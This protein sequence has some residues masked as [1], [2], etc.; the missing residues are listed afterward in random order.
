MET[1]TLNRN[2]KSSR[3]AGRTP[4]IPGPNSIAEVA[5][6]RLGNVD[7]WVMIRGINKDNP[8]LVMLHGGP[9]MS[10]TVFW[11]YYNSEALEKIFTVV[12]WDQRGSG[13][14]FDP[15]LD[16]N[17]MTVEQF[18]S[19]LNDLIDNVC[20]RLHKKQVTIFGHSWGSVLGPLYAARFPD[21]VAAYVGSGQIG[22]WAASEQATYKY[23]LDEAERR[24][25]KRMF[26]RLKEIV[27][28]PPHDCKALISQRNCLAELDGD[29]SWRG[30]WK[31]LW[32]FLRAPEHS[33]KDLFRVYEVLEFSIDTMWA[34]VTSINL[35]ES[36]PELKMPTFFLLGSQDH[37]VLPEISTDYVDRLVAPSKEVVWFENSKHQPFMDEPG[38]FCKTMARLVRPVVEST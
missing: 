19:D 20:V 33:L 29:I 6:L 27:G 12:Y 14:S 26:H 37:C 10:E 32:I 35:L 31:M 38:K 16:K 34:H 24:G 25:W 8:V 4:P 7:Q 1:S 15:E 9:G 23:T 3:H 13:K 17:T 11:R 5:F 30:I 36:V 28:E 2:I 21:K 18:L 22:N